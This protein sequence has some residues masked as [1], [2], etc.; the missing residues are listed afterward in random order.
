MRIPSRD[1]LVMLKSEYM[2]QHEIEQ[3]VEYLNYI[4]YRAESNEQF[5]IAHEL[6]T[7]HRITSKPRKILKAISHYELKPFQF[8]INKN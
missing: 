6:V 1:L 3:Q 5:C 2:S 7:R 8:L 4:L